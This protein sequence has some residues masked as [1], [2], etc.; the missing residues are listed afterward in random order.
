MSGGSSI[1]LVAVNLTV[2]GQ[3]RAMNVEPRVEAARGARFFRRTDLSFEPSLRQ[4][5]SPLSGKRDLRGRDKDAETVTE[6]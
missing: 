2:N 5:R 4:H 6:I 1:E 3:G